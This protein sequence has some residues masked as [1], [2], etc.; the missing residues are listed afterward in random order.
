MLMAYSWGKGLGTSI[1]GPQIGE[2]YPI[3][4]YNRNWK[5]RRRTHSQLRHPPPLLHQRSL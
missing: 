5:S 3:R 1:S 2:N 4:D